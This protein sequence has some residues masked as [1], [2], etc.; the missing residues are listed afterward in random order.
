MRGIRFTGQLMVSPAEAYASAL[1][2][3]VIGGVRR[4]LWDDA[5]RLEDTA[6]ALLVALELMESLA[7]LDQAP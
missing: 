5:V 7:A 1:P 3:R 2:E 4:T 6:M